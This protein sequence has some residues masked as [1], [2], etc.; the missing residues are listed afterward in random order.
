[1]L[2]YKDYIGMCRFDGYGFQAVY[3][4]VEYINQRVSV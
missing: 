4:R 2:P 1:M 3:S